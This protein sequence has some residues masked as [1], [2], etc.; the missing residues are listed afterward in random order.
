[1]R[2]QWFF[3]I[4]RLISKNIPPKGYENEG[5]LSDNIVISDFY[6]E[7]VQKIDTSSVKS[8]S[9]LGYP[10]IF[11]EKTDMFPRYCDL[12]DFVVTLIL[13]LIY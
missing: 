4:L 8:M 1:M 13:T 2:Y 5:I 11:N 9:F 12:K 7:E 10:E 3:P 6:R